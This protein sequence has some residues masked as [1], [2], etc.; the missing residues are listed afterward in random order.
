M[1]NPTLFESDADG[2]KRIVEN[3]RGIRW[4]IDEQLAR[5]RTSEEIEKE[6]PVAAAF[7]TGKLTLTDLMACA[8]S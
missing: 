5:G 6:L 4:W 8:T 7:I 1:R 3:T 2:V